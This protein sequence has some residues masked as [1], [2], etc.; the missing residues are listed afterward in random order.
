MSKVISSN[1]DVFVN[2][3]RL[4]ISALFEQGAELLKSVDLRIGTH[5]HERDRF[6]RVAPHRDAIILIINIKL[7]AEI[8]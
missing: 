8:Q 1:P 7:K 2:A 4:G 6:R 5:L 3:W